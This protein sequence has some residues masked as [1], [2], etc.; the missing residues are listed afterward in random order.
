M[1]KERIRANTD[2]EI[3]NL[4]RTTF[5]KLVNKYEQEDKWNIILMMFDYSSYR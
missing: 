2:M 5:Y 4:K 1:E 3:L